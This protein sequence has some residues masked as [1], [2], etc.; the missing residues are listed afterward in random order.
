M[1]KRFIGAGHLGKSYRENKSSVC[2]HFE[3][4][5]VSK[6]SGRDCADSNNCQTYKFYRAY[7]LDYLQLGVGAICDSELVKKISQNNNL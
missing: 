3:Y 2:E 6:I 5:T 4:C 7:G 1:N